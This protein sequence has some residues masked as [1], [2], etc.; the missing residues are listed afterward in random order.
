M[1]P[2]RNLRPLSDQR[3]DEF[4]RLYRDWHATRAA[5]YDPDLPEDDKSS[6]APFERFYAAQAALMTAPAPLPWAVFRKWELL[7]H[8]MTDEIVNGPFTVEEAVIALASIKADVL[9][10]ARKD[11]K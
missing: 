9:R 8:L 11:P 5:A 2:D 7:E 10:F 1:M 4:E 3:R 6:D